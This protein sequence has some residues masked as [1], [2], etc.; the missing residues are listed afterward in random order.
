MFLYPPDE[1]TSRKSAKTFDSLGIIYLKLYI[2]YIEPIRN[3]RLYN[4][5]ARQ[6]KQ[7]LD[8]VNIPIGLSGLGD[9]Q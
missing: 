6:A 9:F 5:D 3:L 2:L 7:C 1:E 8:T 4:L